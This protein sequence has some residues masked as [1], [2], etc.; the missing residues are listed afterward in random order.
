[1]GIDGRIYPTS[2]IPKGRARSDQFAFMDDWYPVQVKQRDKIGRPDV[3]QFEAVMMRENRERGFLVGFDYTQDALQEIRR[4]EQRERKQ[5]IPFRVSEL[6]EDEM[7]K[8]R[9]PPSPA[10]ASIGRLPKAARLL[11]HRR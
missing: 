8:H 9:I 4:F 1:M 3:D 7:V 10:K 5:I 6:L 2:A 11:N